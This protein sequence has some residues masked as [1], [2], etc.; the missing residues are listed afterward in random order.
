MM[1]P[2]TTTD[3]AGRIVLV[4][5]TSPAVTT[6]VLCKQA[7]VRK[8]DVL[9]E[10]ERLPRLGLLRVEDG[11]RAS[12]CWYLVPGLG[13]QFLTCSRASVETEAARE[14]LRLRRF[15]PDQPR[16]CRNS[17]RV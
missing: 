4:V 10:L 17:S 1:E 6:N 7:R 8:V 3:L 2:P 12:K 14:R 9:A 15:P 13:N 5:D 16:T 11:H